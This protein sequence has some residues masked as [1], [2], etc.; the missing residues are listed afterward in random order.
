MNTK[1]NNPKLQTP[2]KQKTNN[3]KQETRNQKRENKKNINLPKKQSTPKI[4]YY[5]HLLSI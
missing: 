4:T 5:K 2:N 1:T 3:K